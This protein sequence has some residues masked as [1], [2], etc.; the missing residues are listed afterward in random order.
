MSNDILIVDM[1]ITVKEECKDK[2]REIQRHLIRLLEAEDEQRSMIHFDG[3][4]IW[5]QG[6][7]YVYEHDMD[8]YI[9]GFLKRW[10][11]CLRELSYINWLN[12]RKWS[13]CSDVVRIENGEAIWT[14][15]D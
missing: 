15:G 7:F 1:D 9:A 13:E 4:N 3:L 8:P 2:L 14:A 12:Q 5:A 10:E 6:I 11:D